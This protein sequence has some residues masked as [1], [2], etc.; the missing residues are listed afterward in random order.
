LWQLSYLESFFCPAVKNPEAYCEVSELTKKQ[1]KAFVLIADILAK[2]SMVD[3]NPADAE[4]LNQFMKKEREKL[5][6]ALEIWMTRPSSVPPP[7]QPPDAPLPWSILEEALRYLH[8]TLVDNITALTS[9]L[10]DK[11][12]TCT[13]TYSLSEIVEALVVTSTERRTSF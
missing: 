7:P 9:K 12:V 8:Q 3:R 1:R 5:L 10:T 4:E 11:G 13:M 2:I 6:R